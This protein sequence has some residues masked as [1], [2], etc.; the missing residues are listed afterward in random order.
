MA[1]LKTRK[2]ESSVDAFLEGIA[3]P[4]QREDAKR[5]SRLMEEVTG[6]RPAMWGESMVG[7]GKYCYAY[8]SGRTGEWFLAGFAPRKGNLTLYIMPGWEYYADFLQRLGKHKIG[9]SCLYIKKLDDIDWA[10]LEALIREAV[11]RA[12]ATPPNRADASPSAS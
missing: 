7:F 10:T 11:S 9:K 3:D 2:T 8:A 12:Q 5:V 4:K 1:E 6:D